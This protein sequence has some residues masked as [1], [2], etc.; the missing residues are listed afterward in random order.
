MC[1]YMLPERGCERRAGD[2]PAPNGRFADEAVTL[3]LNK[4]KVAGAPYEEYQVKLFGGGNMFPETNKK[5][6]AASQIGVQ[7]VQAAKRLTEKYGFT[8]MAEHLGGIGHRNVIFEIWSG[9]VWVKHCD[10]L[11]SAEHVPMNRRLG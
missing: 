3:L 11:S 6:E 8:C 4:I 7:N 9:E 2:W 5:R 1:H 10:V